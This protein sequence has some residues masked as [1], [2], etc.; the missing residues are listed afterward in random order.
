[1][2]NQHYYEYVVYPNA[3]VELFADFLSHFDFSH[4]AS[5]EPRAIDSKDFVSNSVEF[6]ESGSIFDDST[7]DLQWHS[8]NGF[9]IAQI[10]QHNSTKLILRQ[11]THSP[12]LFD[13]LQSFCEILSERVKQPIGCVCSISKKQN[14]DWVQTYKDS[15]KPVLC[16][17]FFIAPSWAQAKDIENLTSK[18]RIPIIIDP[19]L[20]FGSGHHATTAMCLELLSQM[21]LQN[22]KVL[23]VGCG[24]GILSIASAKMGAMVYACDVDKQSIE[25]TN[26]NLI[27]NNMRI[28]ELLHGGICAFKGNNLTFNVIVANI[29]AHTLITLCDDFF[30]ALEC[31]GIVILSG[32]LDIY[33]NEVLEKFAPKFSLMESHKRDEWV[34]LKMIKNNN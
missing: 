28:C 7:D 12:N 9:N 20:A 2:T 24:S 19:A 13:E 25:Q 21:Q 11:C 16:G 32:I 10:S 29:L 33:Q 22:T 26:K 15:I 6:I 5:D 27:I 17:R 3:Q 30:H 34:A 14:K 31:G 23:D 1:M 18:E 8:I 4:F